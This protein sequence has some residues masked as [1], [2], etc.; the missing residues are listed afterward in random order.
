MTAMVFMAALSLCAARP[1]L[2]EVRLS[3]WATRLYACFRMISTLSRLL[4]IE[5]MVIPD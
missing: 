5:E 1:I 3:C 2:T 4:E